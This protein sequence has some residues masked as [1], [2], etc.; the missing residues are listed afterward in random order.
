MVTFYQMCTRPKGAARE[1]ITDIEYKAGS[2]SEWELNRGP[3]KLDQH[4]RL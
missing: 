2:R 4:F 1:Y 3:P